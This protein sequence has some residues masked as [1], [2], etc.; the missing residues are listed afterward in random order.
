MSDNII[1]SIG[2]YILYVIFMLQWQSSWNFCWHKIQIFGR[3]P[4][5]E[6]FTFFSQVCCEMV[7]LY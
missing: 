7:Q 4:P 1:F 3:V 5:K 2:S 6:H